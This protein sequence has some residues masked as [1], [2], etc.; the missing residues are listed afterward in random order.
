MQSLRDSFILTYDTSVDEEKRKAVVKDFRRFYEENGGV[1]FQE[2]GVTIKE[3]N[4][5]FVATDMKITEEITRDRIANVFN[6]P[7]I[8]LNSNS[9][10]FS[11]HINK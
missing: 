4:R 7:S 3:M 2:P 10:S 6:V 9:S 1:L 11:G 5:N 8:F